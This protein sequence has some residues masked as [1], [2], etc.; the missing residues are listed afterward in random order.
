MENFKIYIDLD[1]VL[2]N[3]FKPIR[4]RMNNYL[5]NEQNNISKDIIKELEGRNFVRLPD[6]MPCSTKKK[7]INLMFNLCK[8]DVD[9][10]KDLPFMKDGAFLWE[11][12]LNVFKNN[13][14]NLFILTAPVDLDCQK[15][16]LLWIENNLGKEWTNKVIFEKDKWKYANKNNILIDDFEKNI[17]PWK[18]HGGIGIIHDWNNSP[19]TIKLLLEYINKLQ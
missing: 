10:W 8:N 15:G 18:E 5:Q 7:T 11:S 9:F 4:E 14:D 6:I 3:F 13:L 19:R 2:V 16:K 12:L 1:G 17:N